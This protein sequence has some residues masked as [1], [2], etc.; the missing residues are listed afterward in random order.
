MRFLKYESKNDPS[1]TIL[2]ILL[3][4]VRLMFANY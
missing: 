1:K 2:V 3:N 4:Q